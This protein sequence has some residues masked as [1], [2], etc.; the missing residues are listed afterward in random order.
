M[1]ARAE[2]VDGSVV[3]V[4]QSGDVVRPSITAGKRTVIESDY[5]KLV[6]KPRINSVQL[7][8][9][10]SFDELGMSPCSSDDITNL[11]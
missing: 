11:L 9:D 6:N 10:R 7:S 3:R 8:G 2:L 5:E 4:V 1:G